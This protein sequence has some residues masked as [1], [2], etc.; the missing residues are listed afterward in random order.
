MPSSVQTAS[1]DVDDLDSSGP[2]DNDEPEQSMSDVLK[3]D[4]I[5]SK[6][7]KSDIPSIHLKTN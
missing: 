3:N 2:S 7:S 1:Y 6:Y 5:V 4:P